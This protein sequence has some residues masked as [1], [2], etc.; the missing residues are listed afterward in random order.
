[1]R[2]TLIMATVVSVLSAFLLT[3]LQ[4]TAAEPIKQETLP[5]VKQY[6]QLLKAGKRNEA[7]RILL[8]AEKE[9]PNE[10]Q[11]QLLLAISEKARG[12]LDGSVRRLLTQRQK[13]PNDFFSRETL[14]QFLLWKR[15]TKVYEKERTALLDDYEK[16][17]A[18]PYYRGNYRF[19]R[20]FFRVDEAADQ[21]GADSVLVD[22]FEYYG[23]GIKP[24]SEKIFAR[25]YV[26]EMMR[27][28]NQS[29]GFVLLATNERE[30]QLHRETG[31]L[32]GDDLSYYLRYFE[33]R[34]GKV[35]G[36]LTFIVSETVPKFEHARQVVI[37]F[38][39][40]RLTQ[41]T[42]TILPKKQ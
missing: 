16:M 6:R 29:L 10:P 19:S 4:P 33:D 34:Q 18:A 2:W 12:D 14:L 27:P 36:L 5:V 32:K 42:R 7:H 41:R 15:D 24:G 20:E 11:I 9:A 38:T 28:D 39:K 40:G 21:F 22:G 1:M 37:N 30:N 31:V 23:A 35:S 25:Y 17:K 3:L 13:H 8:A 26:F